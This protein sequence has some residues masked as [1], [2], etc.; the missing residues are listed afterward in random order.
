MR[1]MLKIAEKELTSDEKNDKSFASMPA[2]E[3][4][5]ED[6]DSDNHNDSANNNYDDAAI[7]N[8]FYKKNQEQLM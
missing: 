4:L 8:I 5:Y 1:F 7:D 2:K 3:S 6:S